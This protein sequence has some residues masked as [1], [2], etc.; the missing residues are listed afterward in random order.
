MRPGRVAS[1]DLQAALRVVVMALIGRG[2][3][4]CSDARDFFTLAHGL[5][6]GHGKKPVRS[7]AADL[8]TIAS[9]CQAMQV[10]Y[11]K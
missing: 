7:S 2:K 3:F 10:Y 9:L 1:P 4:P 8:P 5:S 6:A 11:R